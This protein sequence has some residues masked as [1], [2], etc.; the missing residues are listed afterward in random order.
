[1]QVTRTF[2]KNI[3]WIRWSQ[4]WTYSHSGVLHAKRTMGLGTR[5]ALPPIW[6]SIWKRS[7]LTMLK[8]SG[9]MN[10]YGSLLL[11]DVLAITF[12]HAY[13]RLTFFVVSIF[14]TGL[15]LFISLFNLFQLYTS[16]CMVVEAYGT[17]QANAFMRGIYS[18]DVFIP[19]A[20][21]APL[22]HSLHQ[23]LKAYLYQAHHSYEASVAAFA[24]VPKLHALHQIWHEMQR[25]LRT[26][27]HVHNPASLSCPIDEDFIGRFACLSRSV[28]PRA[29]IQRTIQRYVCHIYIA[30]ARA[31]EKK[32]KRKRMVRIKSGK[33]EGLYIC[34]VDWYSYIERCKSM[35]MYGF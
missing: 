33:D 7:V 1:M 29:I 15:F 4:R 5:P 6:C 22:V 25:Q 21:A 26:C 27:E 17:M 31:W 28:S 12:S 10:A 14:A 16:S 13:A 30:W 9:M 8:W 3:I 35:K 18:N 24:L 11:T 20:T 2:A 32:R 19:K 23:F 34:S